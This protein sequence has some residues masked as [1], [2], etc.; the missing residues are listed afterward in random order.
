MQ[1]TRIETRSAVPSLPEARKFRPW[2]HILRR[3]LG[4]R[5]GWR[6]RVK[7]PEGQRGLT[8]LEFG[9]QLGLLAARTH[10]IHDLCFTNSVRF[11]RWSGMCHHRTEMHVGCLVHI[12]RIF[13]VQRVGHCIK[14]R[15]KRDCPETKAP[16]EKYP[17]GW[18]RCEEKYCS[19]QEAYVVASS[20][21]S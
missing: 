13:H 6:G 8:R 21:S 12:T 7:G 4:R 14:G 3:G 11:S 18:N 9:A 19:V 1:W 20:H 17:H 5:C 10:S 2:R 16:R 15:A